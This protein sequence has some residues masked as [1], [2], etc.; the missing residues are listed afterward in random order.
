M[1][2]EINGYAS[3]KI[4]MIELLWQ[5][6]F[7]KPEDSHPKKPAYE[8]I[9]SNLEDFLNQI[10]KAEHHMIK[11]KVLVRFTHKAY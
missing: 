1:L 3:K 7:L 8:E 10:C 9:I 4:G 6:G 5:Q 2:T 11:L